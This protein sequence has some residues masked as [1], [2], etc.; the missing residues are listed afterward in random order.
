MSRTRIFHR[1]FVVCSAITLSVVA[2]LVARGE[3]PG[4]ETPLFDEALAV[5][6]QLDPDTDPDACRSAF[7]DLVEKIRAAMDSARMRRP[8][9]NLDPTA[10][11]SVLN[12]EILL[13]REVSY[14]SNKYWRD[15]IFTSALLKHRGNCA[16]TALLY[17]LIGQEL[18]LPI[19]MVFAPGHAFVRWDDGNTVI[20]IETTN[21]GLANS[22]DELMKR[23][24]LSEEDLEPNRFLLTLSSQQIRA[25]LRSLWASVLF[26]L[27]RR[28]EAHKILE[29][30]RPIDPNCPDLLLREAEF[31][32]QEGQIDKARAIY[33]TISEVASGPWAKVSAK[34][35]YAHY[36]ETRGNFDEALELLSGEYEKAPTD[37]KVKLARVLGLLYRHKREFEKALPYYQFI[38]RQ[39]L[40]EQSFN[41]LGS[42]LSEARHNEAAIT[43]LEASLRLNPERFGTQIELAVLYERVGQKEKGRAMFAKIEEPR[44]SKLHW[45][46]SVA[47]YFANINDE[48]KMLEHMA[49]AFKM[50]ASGDTY[51]Y[52]VREQDM[53][54]YRE[55]P[56]FKKLM[57]ANAV[58][59]S[60]AAER[61]K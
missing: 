56:E 21:K 59:K 47:F 45:H 55:H 33:K 42:V 28:D 32:M 10:T 2:N 54:P 41:N 29:S 14:I 17:Y 12:Q 4:H 61:E 48:V 6:K 43:L 7:K 49:T 5:S 27:E 34:L 46:R 26:S 15:S 30:V 8:D 16:S 22:Q 44:E 18:K 52:F 19:V 31:L 11:I 36:L 9:K 37:M 58:A 53:D 23:F 39:R 3:E 35:A 13:G 60:S 24:D 38:A 20:N 57:D 40:D 25:R 50:D 51:Q 1:W